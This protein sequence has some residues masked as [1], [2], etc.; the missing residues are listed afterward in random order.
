MC[1]FDSLS[2]LFPLPCTVSEPLLPAPAVYGWR[3]RAAAPGTRELL[4]GLC[5]GVSV[6][7]VPA[8]S[9][10]WLVCLGGPGWGRQL[11]GGWTQRPP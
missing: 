7:P 1:S 11:P 6:C 2:L 3:L 10:L 8:A 9:P 4:P 5:A